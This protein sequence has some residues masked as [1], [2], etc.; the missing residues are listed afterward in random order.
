MSNS[1][2]CLECP[3]KSPVPGDC[4]VSCTHPVANGER[5]MLLLMLVM[6]G[7]FS[8]I[9]KALG[10]KISAYGAESGWANFP[11]NYD[12]IWVT[13]TCSMLASYQ[14]VLAAHQE[15]QSVEQIIHKES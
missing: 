6:T 5:Q 11:V 12:P 13:G 9:E 7:K 3:F 10:L 8:T 4:H 15:K 1:S 2:P 14:K